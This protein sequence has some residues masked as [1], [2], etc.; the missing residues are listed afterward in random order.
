MG[1]EH[2]IDEP[3]SSSVTSALQLDPEGQA[4]A[5]PPQRRLSRRAKIWWVVGVS[6]GAALV[7]AG[8]AVHVTAN[9]SFDAA[10]SALLD[11]SAAAEAAHASLA[12]V[13]D[14]GA[15]TLEAGEVVIASA[16]DALVDVAARATF[17]DAMAQ[18]SATVSTGETLVT[19]YVEPDAMN[20]PGWAWELFDAI[21]TMD[22][23]TDALLD[24]AT[25]MS[26]TQNAIEAADS[27][28]VG[29]ALTLYASVPAAA[30]AVEA[31][32]VSARNYVLLDFRD[33]AE[34]VAG[35]TQLGS[36][37]ANAFRDYAAQAVTLAAST[38]SELAEKAGP[39]YDTRLD[40]EA[41]ARSIAGGVVLDFD[42]A[43]IVNGLGGADGMAGTATW[44]T[45]R[46]GFS[47]IT[48]TDSVAENWPSADARALVAHEV[49]HSITSKC[50]DL[51]DSEDQ[52][53]NEAWATAWAISLGH[54]AEGNGTQAYG[55]PGDDLIAT[56]A[57]CR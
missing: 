52:A 39:L 20:K 10:A 23:E 18:L 41:Y 55:Y 24:E 8:A 54:T 3:A 56:A 6:V 11:A 44:N 53:A 22:A 13:A 38:Q 31:S 1:V 4:Q 27:A 12:P 33:A 35:Q 7:A 49:G 28:T 17:A 32:N 42:W 57:T 48:L 26:D 47:T 37:A 46:G 5:P 9:R 14:E 2:E 50:S 16:S 36:G 34:A 19:A 29:S 15:G 30:A 51:F 40:I 25:V 21:P 43:P 45:I